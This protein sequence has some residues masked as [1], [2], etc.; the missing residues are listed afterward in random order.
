MK[1]RRRQPPMRAENAATRLFHLAEHGLHQ[2]VD[3]AEHQIAG[4]ISRQSH[5]VPHG[6]RR[7][8]ASPDRGYTEQPVLSDYEQPYADYPDMPPE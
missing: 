7:R 8:R 6:A 1:R 5:Q 2:L 3:K 4:E